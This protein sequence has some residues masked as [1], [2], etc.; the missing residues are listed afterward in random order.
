MALLQIIVDGNDETLT[1]EGYLDGETLD[2]RTLRV[3]HNLF[4]AEVGQ[5]VVAIERIHA[6]LLRREGT[7]DELAQYGRYLFDVA[8]GANWWSLIADKGPHTIELCS[9]P[10]HWRWTRLFWESMHNG[11]DFLA[12]C[13]APEV[14]IVRRLG[15]PSEER[16]A[17]SVVRQLKVLFA[18]GV[19]AGGDGQIHP[20]LEYLGLLRTL[21]SASE[22]LNERILFDASLSSLQMAVRDFQPSV[23]HFICHG[24]RSGLD[25]PGDGDAAINMK[26]SAEDLLGALSNPGAELELP[27]IVMNVCDSNGHP[28]RWN[29]V[30]DLASVPV[31]ADLVT[32]GVPL[33]VAMSGPVSD[34]TARQFTSGFYGE[35]LRSSVTGQ[36]ADVVHAAAAGRRAAMRSLPEWDMDWYYPAMMLERTVSRVSFSGITD[37][38]FKARQSLARRFDLGQV[39]CDRVALL[40]EFD[41]WLS[42]SSARPLAVLNAELVEGI[43]LTGTLCEFARRGLWSGYRPILLERPLG[44]DRYDVGYLVR[45]LVCAT[46]EL[47]RPLETSKST[48]EGA[49]ELLCNRG[50]LILEEVSNN[51]SEESLAQGL[52][53]YL[54]EIQKCLLFVSKGLLIL[55]DDIHCA[56]F[57]GRFGQFADADGM[58]TWETPIRVVVGVK[59][60][61]S[62]EENDSLSFFLRRY[63]S[64]QFA[65]D[66]FPDPRLALVLRFL[67]GEP[68]LVLSRDPTQR[69]AV[70][71]LLA[72]AVD[73]LEG[74]PGRFPPRKNSPK[75]HSLGALI[76][77]MLSI[78]V[79]EVADDRQVMMALK[80]SASQWPFRPAR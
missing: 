57:V 48:G 65:L 72:V 19:H 11:T 73:I 80:Q 40:G 51:N 70:D 4:T 61:R 18:V 66:R 75:S 26:A 24:D 77:A 3:V 39:F 32:R 45:K 63:G 60:S 59:R 44:G 79:L 50:N 67:T 15:R 20:G 74:I 71:K 27:I 43:G 7:L 1:L 5:E 30:D 58:G 22:R 34:G 14:A 29:E 33:V 38:E 76:Q 64:I 31:A 55:L 53:R 49:I 36:P 69:M 78:N 2:K 41:T 28:T 13:V 21:E 8:I 54:A 56:D 6:K 52:R 47:I 9:K 46:M 62:K 37:L 17:A 23:V 42:T 12:R 35:L 25:L 16:G 10:G 68:P